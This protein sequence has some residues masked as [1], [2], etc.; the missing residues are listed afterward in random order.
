MLSKDKVVMV[1]GGFDPI[2]VGHVRMILEAAEY[3]HVWLRF[4]T[5]N[6]DDYY[7]YFVFRHVPKEQEIEI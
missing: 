6:T 4:G 1:S 3:G 7:P 2:H 5:D